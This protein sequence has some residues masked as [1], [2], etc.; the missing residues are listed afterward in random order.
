MH[1]G[2]N[3]CYRIV[4]GPGTDLTCAEQ[5][6]S[7]RAMTGETYTPESLVLL[8]GIKALCEDQAIRSAVLVSM[9]T[10]D[11]GGLA[12]RRWEVT[13]IVGSGSLAP[14]PTASNAPTRVLGGPTM[15]VRPPPG[16]GKEPEPRHKH[17]VGSTPTRKNDKAQGAATTRSS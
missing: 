5:E 14:R 15:E 11:E 1:T 8:R 13:P 2:S 7:I 6:A 4:R 16:R 9:P 12:V 10:L 3:D 17:N